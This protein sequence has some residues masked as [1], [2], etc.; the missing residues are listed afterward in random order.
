M[1][2]SSTAGNN[3]PRDYTTSYPSPLFQAWGGEQVV[4]GELARQP[5]GR[6]SL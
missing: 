4:W 3:P 1:V 2:S 6:V 5:A